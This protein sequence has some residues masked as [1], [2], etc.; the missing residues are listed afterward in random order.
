MVRIFGVDEAG[1]GPVI[2][3]MVMAA[4]AIEEAEEERLVNLKVKDSKLLTRKQ[5]EVAFDKLKDFFENKIVI[6]SAEEIDEMMR[7][8]GM[9][10]N[11]MEAEKTV[12]MINDLKPDKAII[13]CPSPNTN[14][15]ASYIRERLNNPGTALVCAHHAD[16][17]FPVVSAASILA[18]VVRDREIDKIKKKIGVDFGSGYVADPRTQE[19][20]KRYW[21][22]YP[23]IFRHTWE[24]YRE[25]AGLKGQKK[26]KEF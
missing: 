10:L 16:A 5:R 25:V 7:Q 12:I 4:V 8:D 23:D 14:A 11:W 9:N 15:Y 22:K 20:L 17:R 3:P 6:V 13:D 19:F 21:D 26:L 18:K 2:G 1:R 24:P